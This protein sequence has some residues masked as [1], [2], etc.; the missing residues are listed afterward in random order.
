[1][2]TITNYNTLVAAIQEEVEDDGQ[3]FLAFIPTA[4]DLAEERLFRELDLPAIEEKGNG[5]L[6]ANSPVMTMPANLRFENYFYVLV[7][8]KKRTLRKRTEDFLNDYWPDNTVTD[9]PK[10]YALGTETQFVLA[11]V[12]DQSYAYEIKFTKKPPKLSSINQTNYYVNN[13]KDCLL[14]AS[15]VE[16][17]KF[18]KAWSQIDFWEKDFTRARDSWN[19]EM[20]R[21]RRN[22]GETPANPEGNINS[23]KHTIQTN[24]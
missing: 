12:P 9:V 24:S 15:L 8:G 17:A 21:K 22:D 14:F 1:M 7:D 6:V 10:Y 18:M 13:V 4:I 20:M 5:F 11:P 3:E 19:L 16:M 2:T 23:I